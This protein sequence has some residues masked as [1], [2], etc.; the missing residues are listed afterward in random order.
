MHFMIKI[1]LKFDDDMFYG[2]HCIWPLSHFHNYMPMC[3]AKY[4]RQFKWQFFDNK[5]FV[6]HNLITNGMIPLKDNLNRS[7]KDGRGNFLSH[8]GFLLGK[9]YL[10]PFLRK[11]QFRHLNSILFQKCIR[12]STL[13]CTP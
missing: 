2:S 11:I 5:S 7:I 8:R 13:C 10:I 4:K 12:K 1:P 3:T 6:Q 9:I